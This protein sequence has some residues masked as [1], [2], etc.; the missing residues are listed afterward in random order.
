[1]SISSRAWA[2][3]LGVVGCGLVGGAASW[4]LLGSVG[5]ASDG[6][7]PLADAAPRSSAGPGR[8]VVVDAPP[9]RAPEGPPASAAPAPVSAAPASPT[10]PP[11]GVSGEAWGRIMTHV[12]RSGYAFE[13]VADPAGE[14]HLASNRAQG[15]W[16][17]RGADGWL[18]VRPRV[19]GPWREGAWRWRARVRE[20]AR[21]GRAE[22]L[23]EGPTR[24]DLDRL[25]VERGGVVEWY[26]NEPQGVEQGFTVSASPLGSGP[27]SL[28]MELDTDLAPRQTGED[29]MAFADAGGADV[30]LY[31]AL[32]AWDATGRELPARLA[33][34]GGAGLSIEVEDAGAAYPLTIDPRI[35]TQV[36]K[37]TASDGAGGD[38]F[39]F[40]VAVSGDT[41]VVGAYRDDRGANGNQ[42]SAYVFQR[43]QGGADQWGQVRQLTASDGAASDQFGSS[44]AVSGDTVV[45]GAYL[46]DV[47]T[48]ADQGSAYVFQRNQ[49]GADEWGQVRQL[50][51]SDGTASDHFGFSVA[52]SGDTVV[53]GAYRNGSAY[54]FQRNQGGADEWGQVKQLT[55]SGGA[56][57]DRFGYSVR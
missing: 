6:G 44:V 53:V 52:V 4:A 43:N 33:W 30:L 29:A 37:L 10:E 51:A 19:E 28:R 9:P 8:S 1:M 14:V 49:G 35:H 22:P 39:G 48:N 36:A 34:D 3:L 47:G 41:L 40:S 56:A 50:T 11:A 27:L 21:D 24:A 15:L 45:V 55:A 38:E 54:V 17:G 7:S 23:P 18:E 20:L 12:R 13:A 16:A 2:G 32:L 26:V 57:A 25:E 31:D 42:G 5:S 46:D